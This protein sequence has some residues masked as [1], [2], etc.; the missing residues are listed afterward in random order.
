MAQLVEGDLVSDKTGGN[1][2]MGGSDTPRYPNWGFGNTVG[3]MQGDSQRPPESAR[4]G[5][6]V[7]L[8]DAPPETGEFRVDE[9]VGKFVLYLE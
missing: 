1:D 7:Q 9:T 6:R 4:R 2:S 8:L 5:R 3:E